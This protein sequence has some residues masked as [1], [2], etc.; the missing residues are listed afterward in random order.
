MKW[1]YTAL[2]LAL[3]LPFLGQVEGVIVNQQT[4]LPQAYANIS[5]LNTSK[6]CVANQKGEF[7]LHLPDATKHHTIRISA[8]DIETL[9]IDLTSFTNQDTIWVQ[10]KVVELAELKVYNN[11]PPAIEM[12]RISLNKL[13][14]MGYRKPYQLEVFYRHYCSEKDV[15]GR[16]IEAA[17]TLTDNKGHKKK[18]N[19]PADKMGVEVTQLR[20]SY[21]FTQNFDEHEPIS[22]YSTL[23][24]DVMSYPSILSFYPEEYNFRLVDTAFMD[25]KM[26]W[27]VEYHYDK[28]DKVKTD[29]VRENCTGKIYLN[30]EDYG[31]YLIEE[32]QVGTIEKEYSTTS[33]TV[34]WRVQYQAF[35]G[36]YFLKYLSETS[37]SS[38]ELRSS[39]QE[40]VST[41]NHKAHVEMMV[42]NVKLYDVTKEARNEPTKEELDAMNYDAVFWEDYTVLK[43]SP[44]DEKI[45]N[46]LAK[47]AK[48]ED[49][50]NGN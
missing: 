32:N 36:H 28:I 3:S 1:I 41:K 21:D 37:N 24:Y 2:L 31:V 46:D 5:L 6:G 49:Q 48:L 44:L 11:L 15:Y 10:E 34:N 9:E 47:R 43:R 13:P 35:E 4:G 45:L 25:N 22:V 12:I 38:E 17:V 16:L 7:A 14:D 30:A 18:V 8:L 33:M 40:V 19:K 26:L 50:F 39:Q 20:K 23:K 29:T 27:V 42:N